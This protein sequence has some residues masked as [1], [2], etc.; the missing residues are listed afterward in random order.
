MYMRT[1]VSKVRQKVKA[2][3]EKGFK[4]IGVLE[5]DN[6]MRVLDREYARLQFSGASRVGKVVNVVALTGEANSWR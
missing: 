1:R 3:V 5:I 6:R 4:M 2:K